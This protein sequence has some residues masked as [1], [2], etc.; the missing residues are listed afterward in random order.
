MLG[1]FKQKETG[2]RNADRKR[3]GGIHFG[4]RMPRGEIGDIRFGKRM[5]L[6]AKLL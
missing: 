4:K 1:E 3:V 5:P 2:L 6:Q